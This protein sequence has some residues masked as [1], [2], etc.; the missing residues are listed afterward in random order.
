[1][2]GVK[3]QKL[4][5]AS[6]F[7][8][9][10]L[11]DAKLAVGPTRLAPKILQDGAEMLARSV[12]YTFASFGL[13]HSGGS[14][15]INAKPDERDDAITAYMEDMAPLVA[16]GR[17]LTWPGTGVSA[18][19]LAPLRAGDARTFDDPEVL[20][21]GAVAA[22]GAMLDGGLDGIDVAFVGSG[23]LVDA[24]RAALVGQGAAVVDGEADAACQALF[25][26]GKAG[27]I[28]HVAAAGVQAKV[29]VP[30]TPLAVTAKAYA[31][32]RRAET[33][34]VPDFVALAAPLLDALDADH[35]DGITRVRELAG[36]LAPEG[37]GA[38]L[39]ACGLAEAFLSTW[40]DSLPFGRP[41]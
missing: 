35:G 19:D 27:A 18:S 9:I 21:G 30:L 29:V 36:A 15:G 2:P 24:A 10:D 12:T 41:I 39:A 6:G 38:W 28:D 22:A 40:Q 17:W 14:A 8:V 1:M 13:Q 34:Y 3:I 37:P 7:V 5:K 32:L 11:P 25:V 33:T 16:D 31:V 23:P 4:E 26:A 20:A